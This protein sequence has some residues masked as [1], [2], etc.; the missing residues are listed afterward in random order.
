MEKFLKKLRL[1]ES[2]TT[3]VEVQQS[4]FIAKFKACVDEGGTGVFSD[5]FDA[6]SSSKNEYKGYVRLENF[7]IK[8]RKRLFDMNMSMAVAEGTFKQNDDTLI[9]ETEINAFTG[10]MIPF[11]L[12]A[13]VFYA[14]FIGVLLTVNHVD[15]TVAGFA[16]PFIFLHAAFMFGIPYFMMRQSVRR[17]K[18]ELEREFFYVA[19]K[20]QC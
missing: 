10:M 15:G 13:V 17:M 11:Y 12:I 5:A 1:I 4:E 2:L 7:K 9:I 16:L 20:Q 19:N 14:V 6:F 3:E 8:R 18:Y